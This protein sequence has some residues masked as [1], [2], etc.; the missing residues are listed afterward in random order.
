VGSAFAKMLSH[1]TGTESLVLG[2]GQ[3]VPVDH[4]GPIFVATQ[5]DAIP[6]VIQQTPKHLHRNLVFLQNGY[7]VPILKTHGL[8]NNTQVLLYMSA[9]ASG[10]VVD[11]KLTTACGRW[12]DVTA[13]V[14]QRGGV[15]CRAVDHEGF[16]HGQAVKLLW[17]SIFW[18]MCHSLQQCTVGQVVEHHQPEVQRLVGELL[19]IAM[20]LF[21]ETSSEEC[22][23][24]PGSINPVP[25]EQL[26]VAQV[27]ED[28]CN[29]S[30]SIPAAVPSKDMALREF[31]WRNG[32]LLA[33]GAT[34]QPLHVARLRQAGCPEHIIAAA[35]KGSDLTGQ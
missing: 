12:A 8:L 32:P 35:L 16:A 18:V 4:K 34:R 26:V 6:E 14:L 17:A 10:D 27:T 29:Y 23:R 20:E 33:A 25:D 15:H 7:L 24:F 13:E 28:L 11:G 19:P 22:H 1:V 30:L 31:R 2:R 3:F 21:S 9:S 5:N